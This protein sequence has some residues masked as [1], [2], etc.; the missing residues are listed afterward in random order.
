MYI[1]FAEIDA[2]SHLVDGLDETLRSRPPVGV[3]GHFWR[4]MRASC[5]TSRRERTEALNQRSRH[6]LEPGFSVFRPGSVEVQTTGINVE[7]G[8]TEFD[9]ASKGR[10]GDE[11][12][13]PSR[14]PAPL[15]AGVLHAH[16]TPQ[17]DAA[18]QTLRH[19]PQLTTMVFICPI[20]AI[21][22]ADFVRSEASW[23]T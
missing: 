1:V 19:L 11:I 2:L 23:P 9:L 13:P 10:S 4:G 20:L 7:M 21:R 22:T 8:D 18:R 16:Q 14:S 5:N 6:W 15:L 12:D 3:H 17:K